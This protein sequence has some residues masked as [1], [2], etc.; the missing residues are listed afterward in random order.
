MKQK[1]FPERKNKRKE[2]AL[3][4]IYKKIEN[5][6]NGKIFQHQEFTIRDTKLNILQDARNIKTKKVRHEINH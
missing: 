3:E 5:N 6:Q 4:R 2:K 1:N